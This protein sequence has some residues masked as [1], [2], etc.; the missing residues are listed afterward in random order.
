MREQSPRPFSVAVIGGGIGG[1]ASA[2]F[3]HHHCNDQ[4]I[5]IHVYEQ[6][7]QYREIGAGIGIGINAAKLLHRIDLGDALNDIAGD[8]N[9]VWISFRRF[10][11]GNEIVTVPLDDKKRLRPLPV[12][13][14]QFLDLLVSA[15]NERKAAALHTDKRC[16][17]VVVSYCGPTNS[18]I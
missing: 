18:V 7:S 2:L 8:R 3:L 17:N 16:L 14:S 10:D 15:I 12:Q 9:G 1:L 5:E 13:R 11:D 4:G 6:A